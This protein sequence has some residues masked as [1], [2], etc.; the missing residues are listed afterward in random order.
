VVQHQV[1]MLMSAARAKIITKAPQKKSSEYLGARSVRKLEVSGN[2]VARLAKTLEGSCLNRGR[3]GFRHNG[4][5]HME[6]ASP[7]FGRSFH[8]P[9]DRASAVFGTFPIEDRGT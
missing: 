4:K 7:Y 8:E 2:G 5:T 3:S 6:L 9:C 1:I